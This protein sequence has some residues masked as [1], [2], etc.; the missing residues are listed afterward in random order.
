MKKL[1]FSLL[2]VASLAITSVNAGDICAPGSTGVCLDEGYTVTE[3]F[4]VTIAGDCGGL[5]NPEIDS[6]RDVNHR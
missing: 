6:P 1:I 3:Y 5:W 4:P 2:A